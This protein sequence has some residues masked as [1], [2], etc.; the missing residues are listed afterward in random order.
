MFTKKL[1]PA[2]KPYSLR[3]GFFTILFTLGLFV[4]ISRA[5]GPI[6]GSFEKNTGALEGLVKDVTNKPV[7]FVILKLYNNIDST[8]SIQILNSNEHGLYH[9]EKLKTGKYWVEASFSGYATLKSEIVEVLDNKT[10]R[11]KTLVLKE[12]VNTL[13]EV[14]VI[15]KKPF[16]E[17][18][19]DKT[20]LNVESDILATGEN[21]LEVL[22]KAPG[23]IIDKD[24]HILLQGK[25]GVTIMLDGKLTYL[26]LDALTSLLKNTAASSIDQIE[27]ITQPSAKYDASGNSGIINIKTKKLKKAGLNGIFTS[28]I[29]LGVYLHLNQGLNLNYKTGKWN[30]FGS[31]DYGLDKKKN[32]LFINRL[33]NST[34]IL[35]P[36]SAFNEDGYFTNNFQNHNFKTGVDYSISKTQILG[37]QFNGY[38]YRGSTPTN[39]NTQI[40]PSAS[41]TIPDSILKANSDNF[42]RGRG[43]TYNLN[44][45]NTLDTTGQELSF[46]IDYSTFN[47]L[48]SSNINNTFY[49]S[50]AST[51]PLSGDSVYNVS[52]SEGYIR[53]GKLDYTLPINKTIKL[54]L[55]AKYS[56]VNTD[57]N[58]AY[59]SIKQGIY[60]PAP[61]QSNHFLYTET[62]GAIYASLN[63]QWKK[64]GIV[65]GLRIENTASVGNSINLKTKTDRNYLDFF[66]NFSFSQKLDSNN[67]FGLSYS[68]RID[69]PS[70]EDLNPFKFYLDQFTYQEG[71]PYL[72]PQYTESFEVSNT[73]KHG[74]FLSLNFSWT[75]DISVGVLTQNDTTKVTKVMNENLN[76]LYSYGLTFSKPFN[77]YPWWNIN[78]NLNTNYNKY[79]NNAIGSLTALQ[80]SKVSGS[81]NLTNT[82]TLPDNWAGEISGFYNAPAIYGYLSANAQYAINVGIQKSFLK[83]KANL[84]LGVN[85]IF[86]INH[87]SGSEVYDNVNITIKNYYDSRR[88]SLSFTYNFGTNPHKA[89]KGTA[90]QDE[91]NRVKH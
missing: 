58:V 42:N 39:N 52:P 81:L 26:S 1:S 28:G 50:E 57:N 9:F 74:A 2:I 7:P 83:K 37:F 15:V 71:N 66:P 44:Y 91:Q 87:F 86:N 48:N 25:Q 89:E 38:S 34:H 64:T 79:T 69:R 27:I 16:I 41:S 49:R 72:K 70:Y 76:N 59:D 88:V 46:N 31:Y 14:Q 51:K 73:F 53:V 62:V 18:K 65:L 47:N 54:D 63:K 80:K 33:V 78:L 19:V 24:D 43:Y 23:V 13:K 10:T 75:K 35:T 40:L 84:K 21:V 12:K 55:G 6:M 85:D 11:F 45:K 17:R 22:K 56:W 77:P 29:G 8:Q 32:H 60:K 5:Q 3:I 68:R 4:N 30:F 61:T 82:F 90:S 36:A 67:Q 20:V